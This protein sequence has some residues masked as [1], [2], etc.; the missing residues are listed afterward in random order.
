MNN[1]VYL[2]LIAALLLLATLMLYSRFV[3]R[4][5]EKSIH[6]APREIA[7]TVY[8]EV[9]LEDEVETEEVICDEAISDEVAVPSELSAELVAEAEVEDKPVEEEYLD[10]LQEAAAGLAVLMRSSPVANRTTPVVFAPDDDSAEEEE[11]I[12]VAPAEVSVP[13]SETVEKATE[14][15]AAIDRSDSSSEMVESEDDE[16]A[17]EV[18]VEVAV[19][20]AP[21]VEHAESIRLLLGEDVSDQFVLIDSG[22][23][24]L[25]ELVLSLE[26]GIASLESS[27][28]VEESQKVGD[29]GL[30]SEAA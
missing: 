23:D 21:S 22:L 27:E 10:E 4:S 16:V 8:D 30:V 11:S 24:A 28:L 13:L 7:P 5:R 14:S 26:E 6:H 15:V 9:P 2:I 29:S 1:W 3:S 19:E 12:E 17:A 25:E 18:A 20:V